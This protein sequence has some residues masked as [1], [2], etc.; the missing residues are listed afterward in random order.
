[1]VPGENSQG[2]GTAKGSVPLG[3]NTFEPV[4]LAEPESMDVT[5]FGPESLDVTEFGP[6]SLDVT[7]FGQK[8]QDVFEPELKRVLEMPREPEPEPLGV[9]GLDL[10][11]ELELGSPGPVEVA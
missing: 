3:T 5:E 6:E 2:W 1:M 7:E 10:P 9:S 4:V 11:E 8:P